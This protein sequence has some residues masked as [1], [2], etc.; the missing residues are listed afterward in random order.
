LLAPALFFL[1]VFKFLF[2]FLPWLT[3]YE[4]IWT[5]VLGLGLGMALTPSSHIWRVQR[6]PRN[7]FNAFLVR[8]RSSQSSDEECGV[9][10][11]PESRGVGRERERRGRRLPSQDQEGARKVPRDVLCVAANA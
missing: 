2:L 8:R 9:L 4:K 10:R 3:F 6:L 1:Q 5:W 7:A 11:A